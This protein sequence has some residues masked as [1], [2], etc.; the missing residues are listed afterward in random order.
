MNG[1]HK[2]FSTPVWS[3]EFS[4]LNGYSVLLQALCNALVWV[5]SGLVNKRGHTTVIR[6]QCIAKGMLLIYLKSLIRW[7]RINQKGDD[8]MSLSKREMLKGDILL[9]ILRRSTLLWR[10]LQGKVWEPQLWIESG[11]HHLLL[12]SLNRLLTHRNHEVDLW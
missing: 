3:A 2:Q 7:L 9:L 8:Y 10:G 1:Y 6:S 5:W 11:P 12:Q 4:T